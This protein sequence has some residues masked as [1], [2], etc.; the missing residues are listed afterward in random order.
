MALQRVLVVDDEPN[1]RRTVAACVEALG[2]EVREAGDS[3]TAVSLASAF[4]PEVAFLDLRLGA[5]NGLDVLP[6]ILHEAPLA[7]VVVMTAFAS[8]PTAVEAVK[9]GAFDYL[10]KPFTPAQIRHVLDTLAERRRLARR[11]QDLELRVGAE[12]PDLLL[13]SGSP[14]MQETLG[15][16]SRAAD[17]DASVLL[18]GESGT[19]KGVLARL[20]HEKSARASARFVTVS[21]PTLTDEL[22]TAEL[23]GHVRGAFTGAVKDRA[24]VVEQAHSG[25]LFLDEVGEVSPGLQAKLLRFA[26]DREFERVGESRTRRADVRLVAATNR[27]LEEDVVAGRFR[28]DLLYRLNVVEVTVPSLRDRPEDILPLARH[29]LAFF[30]RSAGKRAAE[31]SPEAEAA[32]AAHPWPGNVRELRNEMERA[33]VLGRG[34]TLGPESFST[35]IVARVRR[36]PAVGGDFTLDE[37][38]REHI[39]RV[40]ARS[41]TQEEAA[42]LL[43]ID[44]S[45]LWRKRKRHQTS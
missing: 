18:R 26:Q 1:I 28:L 38:T 27:D 16:L 13:A 31:L 11:V 21:C 24:G 19:G 41:G 4:L 8:Y 23:F 7:E 14:A 25:T 6:R 34:R 10:P 20:V 5:E 37:L 3:A 39:E 17:S 29:F 42:R 45:T 43:G 15:T 30:A 22:L 36:V 40:V 44:P 2:C 32:L 12:L 9:R 33:L 35:R